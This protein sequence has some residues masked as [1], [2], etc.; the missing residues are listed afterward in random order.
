MTKI[1]NFGSLNIDYVY[2]VAD[3]VRPGETIA[4][5]SREINCGGKGLNQSI[6]AAGSGARVFHAGRIGGDGKMLLV[7]LKERGVNVDFVTV[8]DDKSSGHAIIQVNGEGQN[9]IIVC[10]AENN[11]ITESQIDDVLG[12]F[13]A[14]DF[15]LLQNEIN[16][17]PL[18]MKK[19]ASRGMRI[20]FNPSPLRDEI[21]DYPLEL[22]S[23]FAVNEI[24]GAAIAN[25]FVSSDIS[26]NP[27]NYDEILNKI[28]EIYPNSDILLTL[29]SNGAVY[30]GCGEKD[31]FQPIFKV[32]VVDTTGAGD[33]MLGFFAGLTALGHTP[34]SALELS[35]KAS[36]ITVSGKGAAPSIPTI[37]KVLARKW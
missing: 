5:L 7:I 35:A 30:R 12:N 18:I 33:T 17:V 3:F 15:I 22:V 21:K 28:S 23:L 6:A 26:A 20:V 24:E 19:A 31:V 11:E 25:G 8:S 29:G 1:L 4:A 34:A 9:S 2:A 14:G 13:S 32:P 36:A 10:A 27:D 37:D 16:N